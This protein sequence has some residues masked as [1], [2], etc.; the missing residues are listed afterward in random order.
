MPSPLKHII[1]NTP[2]NIPLKHIDYINKFTTEINRLKHKYIFEIAVKYYYKSKQ[3]IDKFLKNF[4]VVSDDENNNQDNNFGLKVVMEE[5]PSVTPQQSV[6]EL[7]S[8]T[9]LVIT[10]KKY[11]EYDSG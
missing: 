9:S 8:T 11:E 3:T 1:Y 4:K 2:L 7:I 6:N 5:E 10:K